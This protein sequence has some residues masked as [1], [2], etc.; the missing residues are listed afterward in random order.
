MAKAKFTP[1]DL[2]KWARTAVATTYNVKVHRTV[3]VRKDAGQHIVYVAQKKNSNIYTVVFTTT[4]RGT[5][6][7]GGTVYLLRN[8]KRVK[9]KHFQLIGGMVRV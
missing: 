4:G 3:R 5:N 2:G 9:P 8:K 1:K 6:V 7:I